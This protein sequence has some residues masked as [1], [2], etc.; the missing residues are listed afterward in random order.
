MGQLQRE[1]SNYS[2]FPTHKKGRVSPPHDATNANAISPSLCPSIFLFPIPPPFAFPLQS[3]TPAFY[4][5]PQNNTA[6]PCS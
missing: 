1:T 4:F 5:Y 2:G 3:A 6:F